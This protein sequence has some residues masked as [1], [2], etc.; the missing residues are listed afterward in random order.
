MRSHKYHICGLCLCCR[1][2]FHQ[3]YDQRNPAG[4][5]YMAST[6][7]ISQ[8]DSTSPLN[9]YVTLGTVNPASEVLLSSPALTYVPYGKQW[10]QEWY[11]GIRGFDWYETSSTALVE[12]LKDFH[13]MFRWPIW[14]TEWACQVFRRRFCIL[15]LHGVKICPEDFKDADAECSPQD[16]V[17]FV[18][19]VTGEHERHGMDRAVH[20]VRR[21]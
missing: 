2:E 18:N 6:S 14:V 20:L 21:H 13:Q 12:H 10:L 15:R 19:I 16:I 4:H 11:S 1:G 3:Q 17:G 9:L 8:H 5:T 7:L